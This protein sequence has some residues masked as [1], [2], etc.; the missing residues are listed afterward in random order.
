VVEDK[1]KS[2]AANVAASFD[3]HWLPGMTI[4]GLGCLAVGIFVSPAVCAGYHILLVI[5]GAWIAFKEFQKHGCNAL[6]RS[7]WALLGL[8][9]YGIIATLANWNELKDPARSLG[10]L[11][12]FTMAV[13]GLFALRHAARSRV[14]TQAR[15]RQ[16]A[17]LFL[18]SII[19]SVT[20]GLVATMANIDLLTFAPHEGERTGGFTGTMRFG[21]GMAMV[22]V[23]LVGL[24]LHT[25]GSHPCFHQNLLSW[26]IVFGAI[27][28][29]LTQTR[30]ALLGCLCGLP[31]ALYLHR[32]K[33][34]IW[35][36][37]AS[38]IIASILL[39]GNILGE[40]RIS[41]ILTGKSKDIPTNFF[42]GLEGDPRL[43][44]Y[45]AGLKGIQERPLL[46][47]GMIGFPKHI[48]SIKERYG[49]AY[50][51]GE[52]SHAHNTFI[53]TAANLGLPGLALLLAWL[54]FW[55]I[56]SWR[57]GGC[58]RRCVVPLLV[59][60]IVAGQFEY[61]FDANNAFLIFALYSLSHVPDFPADN[62]VP[63][64][65]EQT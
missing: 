61:Y 36:G 26:A 62:P 47:H 37:I 38:T 28:L 41:R 15:L 53:D 12:Y 13:L 31:L 23:A 54:S 3:G 18:I 56:E 7:S 42:R 52:A 44:L 50:P 43:S 55:G 5:P 59:V 64:V 65:I 40:E 9:A 2:M 33:A 63:K 20:Y 14:M 10:K 24:R 8:V 39:I 35:M 27:G 48:R 4:L 34:G 19:V 57:R 29:I 22:L 51:D 60:F 11:K 46:G 30:G 16:I 25:G 45:K 58:A 49:I 17:N 32:P 21:Y 6:P 1:Q